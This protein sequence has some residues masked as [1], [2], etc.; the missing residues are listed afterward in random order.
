[1]N[2]WMRFAVRLLVRLMVVVAVLL[3]ATFAMVHATPGDPA[4]AIAGAQ[5]DEATVEQV[6]ERLGLD[7]TIEDQFTAYVGGLATLDLGTS[8]VT[9]ESVRSVVGSRVV[10]TAQVALLG[11]LGM[12]VVGFV[13]GLMGAT[14]MSRGQV[15]EGAFS[16]GTGAMAALPDYLIATVLA[17]AFAVTLQW[18]P[19]GGAETWQAA[20]LPAV[21]VAIRPAAMIARI[22]RVQA[23]DVL[24][25]DYIRVARSKRL[26]TAALH[27]R[28]VLPNTLTG[29]LSAAGIAF[30]TILGGVLVVELVFA[31][32]GLGTELVESIL[33]K[34]YPVVQGI[35]L[36]LG[37]A[38]VL[39]NT[40]IDAIL[41]LVDPRTRQP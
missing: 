23:L 33:V 2:Q 30:A 21:A 4:R 38:V 16:L 37:V 24:A 29:A 8:F 40:L 36:T 3:V 9:G 1:M 17:F 20:V 6:R 28:H 32:P 39:M 26:R 12:L 13:G 27:L 41:G 22:V 7:R 34:D 18:F 35:M 14:V 25:Q 15:G 5:A 11:F 19:A 10:P 31:R